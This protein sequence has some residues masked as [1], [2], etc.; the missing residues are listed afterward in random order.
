MDVYRV[1]W[2]DAQG[3]TIFATS[4]SISAISDASLKDNVRDLDKGLDTIMALQP[5][6]FDWKNGDGTDVMGFIAQ[7]VEEVMPELVADY[8]YSY[9]DTKKS[10]KMGDMIPAMVKA[11][12]EQQAMIE[13]L[14]AEVE[15]LK[16]A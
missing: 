2:K 5:R 9:E 13:A 1:V 11:M 14:K 8:Q 4:T 10:L 15:A 16:N 6:R 7:E 12:Q 3:G